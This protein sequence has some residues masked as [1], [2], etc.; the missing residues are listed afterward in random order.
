MVTDEL[1]LV[2]LINSMTLKMIN[3]KTNVV[4]DINFEFRPKS[5]SSFFFF[6]LT[7]MLCISQKRTRDHPYDTLIYLDLMNSSNSDMPG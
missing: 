4:K 6:S 5:A 1:M 7:K 2:P 3:L